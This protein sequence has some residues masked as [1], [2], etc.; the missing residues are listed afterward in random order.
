MIEFM[1]IQL[2]NYKNYVKK[3]IKFKIKECKIVD[4]ITNFIFLIISI[5]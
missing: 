2:K 1:I 4:I 3:R 5:F